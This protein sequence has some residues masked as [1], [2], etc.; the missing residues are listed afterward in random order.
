V[1]TVKITVSV[2]PEVVVEP[3]FMAGAGGGPASEKTIALNRGDEGTRRGEWE[4]CG[5]FSDGT[6]IT[7][8]T[9]AIDFIPVDNQEIHLGE[10]TNGNFDC[11]HIEYKYVCIYFIL[12]IGS[13]VR[14]L[15]YLVSRKLKSI[16]KSIEKIVCDRECVLLIYKLRN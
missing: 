10:D 13:G 4:E 3:T 14:H 8:S 2:F 12:N 7:K 16:V 1:H 9:T 15:I 5:V 11:V 6:D